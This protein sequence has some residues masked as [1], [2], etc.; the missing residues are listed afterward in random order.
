MRKIAL[1]ILALMLVSATAAWAKDLKI[2]VL[3]MQEVIEKSEPG[4]EA[5]GDLKDKFQKMR[6]DLEEQKAEIENLRE[7]ME[8]QSLVLSQEAK[9]DKELAFKRK[10][11]DFQD[12]YQTYQRRMQEQ[13]Q[14]ISQPIL[15]VLVD[16]VKSYGKS[17]N[18]DMLFDKRNS[19]LL[20]STEAVDVTN[21]VI[22]EL[23][24]AWRE[25]NQQ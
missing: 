24:R 4:M 17:N 8:K 22:V 3:D 6:D 9:Q 21:P 5:M 7:Q 10:V 20:Y 11:R 12:T 19:G 13:Q 15:Q 14:Q 2:G 23:N 25:Q 1:F 16:V 18:F